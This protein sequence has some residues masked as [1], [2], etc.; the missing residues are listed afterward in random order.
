MAN[1]SFILIGA[2]CMMFAPKV[3]AMDCSLGGIS[4]SCPTLV[5]KED[6]VFCCPTSVKNVNVCCD[7]EEYMK[8]NPGI[9]AGIAV[10][11]LV[12]LLIITICCCCFCSCCCLARRRT[13]RGTVL[14]GQLHLCLYQFRT[15]KWCTSSCFASTYLPSSSS[16]SSFCRNIQSTPI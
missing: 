4:M 6:E 10:A 13:Q 8:T 16:S 1:L 5:D 7:I 11:S 3:Y 14:Y 15:S 2:L 12:I 9:I